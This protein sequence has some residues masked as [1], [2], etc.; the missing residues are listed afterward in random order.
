MAN[1]MKWPPDPSIVT[2]C[3][4]SRPLPG[5]SPAISLSALAHPPNSAAGLSD[6]ASARRGARRECAPKPPALGTRIHGLPSSSIRPRDQ[7]EAPR[8]QRGPRSVLGAPAHAAEGPLASGQPGAW[9][10]R[11]AAHS[12]NHRL[13][14]GKS[15]LGHLHGPL[16][17]PRRRR[18]AVAAP[19][20]RRCHLPAAWRG[21]PG[22]GGS[23][24]WGWGWRSRGRAAAGEAR[25][26]EGALGM[27]SVAGEFV[28]IGRVLVEQ[29]Q[30][31]AGRRL[32]RAAEHMHFRCR[33]L[34]DPCR[35][36][37]GW[38]RIPR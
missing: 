27:L 20:P 30:R 31:L 24:G 15:S 18:A 23:G 13:P 14:R 17:L 3:C 11:G 28:A 36:A 35:G 33:Q 29:Q 26:D 19:H 4:R 37:G 9:G 10:R 7:P 38:W 6:H 34:L 32:Q 2:D 1:F 12:L 21:L 5:P 22:A 25:L 16:G 8:G